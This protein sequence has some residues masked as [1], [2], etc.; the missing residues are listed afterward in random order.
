MV[1]VR[2]RVGMDDDQ[3]QSL[4]APVGSVVGVRIR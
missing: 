3:R 2:V 1:R 4:W